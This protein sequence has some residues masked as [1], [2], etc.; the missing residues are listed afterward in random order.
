MLFFAEKTCFLL[1]TTAGV[2][3]LFAEKTC[4]FL[5]FFA[6]KKRAVLLRFL[7]KKHVFC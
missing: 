7:L 2:W 4:C 6:E 1:K 3:H 5:G